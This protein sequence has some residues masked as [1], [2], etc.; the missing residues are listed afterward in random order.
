MH[1]A[2]YLHC[3]VT[4]LY[5]HALKMKPISADLF[6][7]S[8]QEL[9]NGLFDPIINDTDNKFPGQE[10]KKSI[11]YYIIIAYS[12][13]SEMI[14]LSFNQATERDKLM[15]IAGIPDAYRNDVVLL[16]NVNIRKVI[17]AYLDMQRDFDW[18]HLKKKETTYNDLM[19]AS[20][21]DFEDENGKK[22]FKK[23]LEN[24]KYCDTLFEDIQTLKSKVYAK[25]KHPIDRIEEIEKMNQ[26]KVSDDA[27]RP[28][29]E[30][31]NARH[32]DK[33]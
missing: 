18:A 2:L 16:N 1:I 19:E 31:W 4:S 9:T 23:I 28:S 21:Q 6:I 17:Y 8:F 32:R 10:L 26:I 33:Q 3:M 5:E 13:D 27:E 29:V 11:L 20:V 12:V 22:D 25:Y 7:E 14:V 24:S 15:E 30:S